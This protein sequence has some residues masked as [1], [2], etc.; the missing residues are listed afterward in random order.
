MVLEMYADTILFVY[1]QCIHLNADCKTKLRCSMPTALH[2]QEFPFHLPPC[3]L[4]GLL[5]LLLAGHHLL[6]APDG[7][8]ASFHVPGL[9]VW[10]SA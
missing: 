3:V 9:L 6:R 10:S 4:S 5:I 7:Q 8:I 1:L 2:T